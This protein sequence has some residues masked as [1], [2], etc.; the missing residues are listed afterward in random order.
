MLKRL[1]LALACLVAS[2]SV[3]ASSQYTATKYPIVL[4]HGIL[5]FDEILGVDYWYKVPQTLR[6]GGAEVYV[7]QVANS[8][9]TE[10]RGEQLIQ[11]VEDI[12]AISGAEKVNLIGHSHGGPT[13]RY[14]ASVRPDLVA[15]VTS[16]AGVN[17][18]S[19]V[20]DFV[21]STAPRD[22]A[23]EA[24]LIALY[25]SLAG[26]IDFMS[27]GDF[28]QD[29]LAMLT[30]LTTEGALAFNQQHPQGIPTSDCGEGEYVVNGV[31]YYSWSGG[32]PF[33]NVLDPTDGFMTLAG[34]LIDETND[35]L[36]ASCDSNLGMV[37]RNDYKMNH[38]DEVNQLF[39][40][41]HLFETDPLTLFRYQA[42]RLKNAGL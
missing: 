38:A 17:K 13:V 25:E 21:R 41:H 15:S 28:D 32:K 14:V 19:P 34:T 37:I 7:T 3:A 6:D 22:S 18:G 1:T 33:T 39:G 10:V 23:S 40:I 26:V 27:G 42:N 29:G 24:L 31:R 5:G 36:V 8:Q 16:I 9:S 4:T 30:A 11:Q 2:F 35:G 20:A 12:L